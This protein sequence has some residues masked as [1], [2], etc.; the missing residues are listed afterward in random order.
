M[1]KLEGKNFKE[2]L[3]NFFDLRNSNFDIRI[4]IDYV[5]I[6]DVKSYNDLKIF[7]CNILYRDDEEIDQDKIN[8]IDEF[9]EMDMTVFD[10]W[11]KFI[12]GIND[13]TIEYHTYH[14]TKGKEFDN[15][16]IL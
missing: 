6:E 3:N 12:K 14:S 8:K 11:Y 1:R 10:N 15:V 16:V 7:I 13:K 9:F 4:I 5:L 2:Y